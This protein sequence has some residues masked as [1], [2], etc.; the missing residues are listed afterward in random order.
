MPKRTRQSMGDF[1]AQ[2]A[3][4]RSR[5]RDRV[6]KRHLAAC[7]ASRI[8]VLGPSDVSRRLEVASPDPSDLLRQRTAHAF[9][10]PVRRAPDR[11]ASSARPPAASSPAKTSRLQAIHA[12]LRVPDRS[13]GLPTPAR[14]PAPVLPARSAGRRTPRAGCRGSTPRR[15]A[16]WRRWTRRTIAGPRRSRRAKRQWSPGSAAG[17]NAGSGA[18]RWSRRRLA[19]FVRASAAWA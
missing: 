4:L 19:R 7:G 6:G 1:R 8:E 11:A 3:G 17:P 10:Q 16:G 9:E 2:I 18:P 15:C 5:A 12:G 13:T 14:A